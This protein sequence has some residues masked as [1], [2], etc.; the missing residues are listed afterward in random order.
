[1]EYLDTL[2]LPPGV[3]HYVVAHSHGG[4]VA[5]IALRS[6]KVTC[7]VTALV[8]LSTPFFHVNRRSPEKMDAILFGAG[9]LT[10]GM[11]GSWLSLQNSPWSVSSLIW[12]TLG[13]L[14]GFVVVGGVAQ[15]IANTTAD[16]MRIDELK[17]P[18]LIVRAPADD[19]T[20]PLTFFQ[21]MGWTGQWV[22][23]FFDRIA[24][25]VK[26][27][28]DNLFTFGD[29]QKVSARKALRASSE[30][31][32]SRQ[33]WIKTAALA[34]FTACRIAA[35]IVTDVGISWRLF[36]FLNESPRLFFYTILFITVPL[37][38]MVFIAGGVA[39]VM[40]VCAGFLTGIT[41]L[42]VGPE[43]AI[44]GLFMDVFVES[45]PAGRC[46]FFQLP[47][48]A[49]S[50]ESAS[51]EGHARDD[52]EAKK[53]ATRSATRLRHSTHSDPNAINYVA[54]WLCDKAQ[55]KRPVA[56]V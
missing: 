20:L 14:L 54:T 40:Y 19:T 23:Q 45:A 9:V 36:L 15:G 44:A 49:S 2:T 18:L 51:L 42:L 17:V 1:M 56:A 21:F 43:L 46:D 47:A 32:R 55:A 52:H 30:R 6:P 27:A 25:V 39:L 24:E 28:T 10:I 35:A 7:K 41:S 26:L 16:R 38:A 4:T 48:E 31:E 33:F 53:E 8:C 5:A 22:W 12:R 11:L 3:P 50:N 13:F 34:Y 29:A 37:I